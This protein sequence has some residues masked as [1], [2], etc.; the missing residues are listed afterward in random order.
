MKGDTI[1]SASI[2]IHPSYEMRSVLWTSYSVR[3]VIIRVFDLLSIYLL[4]RTP[5]LAHLLHNVIIVITNSGKLIFQ[6]SQM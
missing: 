6:T 3:F 2:S 1:S 4:V 5:G